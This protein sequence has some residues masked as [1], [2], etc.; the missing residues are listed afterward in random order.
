MACLDARP[1][2]FTLTP[3]FTLTLTLTQDGRLS[4]AGLNAANVAYVAG[5]IHQV[6]AAA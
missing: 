2:L 4:M 3:T 1:T 6:T 5:A